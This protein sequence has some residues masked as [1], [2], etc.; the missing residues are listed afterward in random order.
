M[1][2]KKTKRYDVEVFHKPTRRVVQT[3]TVSATSAKQ[4][5]EKVYLIYKVGTIGP[6]D[7]SFAARLSPSDAQ[8]TSAS[9]SPARTRVE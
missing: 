4:A 3:R 2:E 5:R 7:Y 8:T 9:G 1:G 6:L